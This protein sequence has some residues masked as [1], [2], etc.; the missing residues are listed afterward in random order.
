MSSDETPFRFAHTL[1]VRWGECDM[2]GIVFNPHYMAYV[3]VGLT[4]YW[5]EIGLAYPGALQG[6]DIDIFMV[7]AAQS[8]RDAARYDDELTVALRTA[9]IGTTS[10]RV[11]FAISR[12]STILFHGHASYV[13][14][15]RLIRVPHPMS[16][17]LIDLITCYERT[18]PERKPL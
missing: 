7:A 17:W 8:W 16:A 10:F 6:E 11:E 12:Q 18:P 9:Y 1:R 15:G 13:T 4:E 14:A 2:Q 3:D 5:R